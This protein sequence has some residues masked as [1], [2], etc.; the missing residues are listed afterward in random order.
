MIS[1]KKNKLQNTFAF[2][3]TQAYVQKFE[4][5]YQ[6]FEDSVKEEQSKNLQ[7]LKRKLLV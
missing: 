4:R 5:A 7:S 2:S 3:T 1:A 6:V